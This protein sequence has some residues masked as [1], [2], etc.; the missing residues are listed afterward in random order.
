M[1]GI[2]KYYLPAKNETARWTN[3]E[4]HETSSNAVIIIGSNGSGKSRLG[5]WIEQVTNSIKARNKD[6]SPKVDELEVYR[7]GAQRSLN[8]KQYLVEKSFGDAFKGIFNT[9]YD[10]FNPVDTSVEFNNIDNVLSAIFAKR[11]AQLESFDERWKQDVN[12]G[13]KGREDNIIDDIQNVFCYVFP[14]LSVKFKDREVIAQKNGVEYN[15]VDM[16]DGERV[17]LYL[18]AQAFLVPQNKTILIDEP[19]IHLHNSIMNR[20]WKKIE[21]YRHDC[22]FIY[23]THDVN[24]AASHSH[25]E[26]IWCKSYNGNQ[27]DWEKVERTEIPEELLLSLLGNRMPVIFVEGIQ[28]SFDTQLYRAVYDKHLIVPCGSCV[29]VI[30]RTKSFRGTIQLSHTAAFGI[31]DRD[32]RCEKEIAS[33]ASKGVLTLNVAEVENLFIVEELMRVIANNQGFSATDIETKIAEVKTHIIN[34]R[35]SIQLPKQVKKAT[36]AELKHLL[37]TMDLSG[38]ESDGENS[39]ISSLTS[40]NY[41]SIYKDRE[42]FFKEVGRSGDYAKVLSVYNEKSLVKNTG[43]AF[44]LANKEYCNLVLRLL[45]GDKKNEIKNALAPYLPCEIPL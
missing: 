37:S 30:E 13:F 15:G 4:Q 14:Y 18:I 16:S 6:K 28:N 12:V 22:L 7:I 9:N 17:A 25:A 8:W 32:F 21:S 45:Q 2:Y 31:I 24:F 10:I 5:A 43:M 23:I 3:D 41:K 27:W 36:I 19:E 11:T 35:F 38:I 29:A 1:K 40:I 44:G 33:L 20:L 34:E 39:F 42:D 26:K